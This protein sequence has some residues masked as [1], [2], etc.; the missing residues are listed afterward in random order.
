M[1]DSVFI[2]ISRSKSQGVD[3]HGERGISLSTGF[4]FRNSPTS[5]LG[6]NECCEE[7]QSM[8]STLSP[9]LADSSRGMLKVAYIPAAG[10]S[11]PKF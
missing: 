9:G 11:I 8:S 3:W 7:I 10:F 2:V 5:P 6:R 1:P 4:P